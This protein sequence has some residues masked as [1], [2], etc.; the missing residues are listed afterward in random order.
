[1][2]PAT[3]GR[4]FSTRAEE[5][6]APNLNTIL[7]RR[8]YRSGA[9][10]LGALWLRQ[11]SSRWPLEVLAQAVNYGSR[12][13]GCCEM[14]PVAALARV[15]V[16]DVG[17]TGDTINLVGNTTLILYGTHETVFLGSGHSTVDD[18]S[19]GIVVTVGP[20]AGKD[21]LAHFASDP[22]GVVDLIWG[23][24]GFTTS[25]AVLVALKSDGNGGTLLSFGKGN[26][27]LD[28]TE[29]CRELQKRITG[30]RLRGSAE[31]PSPI[32]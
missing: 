18:F 14:H 10:H 26:G 2:P 24:G 32:G 23:I 9:W 25:A 21:I 15:L 31:L 5:L 30:N 4:R 1:M 7:S 16:P 19:T 27:S 8:D 3:R 29:P 13:S 20:T 12:V 6:A 17:G 11:V 22:T 28:F